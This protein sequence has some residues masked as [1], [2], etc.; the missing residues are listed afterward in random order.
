MTSPGE[1]LPAPA[2]GSA[3][4]DLGFP[5][6]ACSF[7]SQ[8]V[9]FDSMW[10]IDTSQVCFKGALYMCVCVCVNNALS[11]NQELSGHLNF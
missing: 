4:A 10:H 1:R 2:L 6:L 9:A 11:I 3:G 8:F 7:H 5:P